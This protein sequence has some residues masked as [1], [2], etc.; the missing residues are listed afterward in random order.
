MNKLILLVF[1]LVYTSAGAAVNL[2]ND[3]TKGLVNDIQQAER[4]LKQTQ[5][6]IAKDNAVLQQQL[7]ELEKSVLALQAKTAV[8]RRATDEQTLSLETLQTRLHDWQQQYS[9]QNNLL[10]R[11][12]QQQGVKTT[13][14]NT[15][16][17]AILALVDTQLAQL[18]QKSAPQWQLQQLALQDGQL[19]QLKTLT[20]GPMHWF[21]DE[22]TNQ[23]GIYQINQGIAQVALNFSTS[24]SQALLALMQQGQGEVLFDPTLERAMTL[25]VAQESMLDHIKK[26]G[27]WVLPILAFGVFALLIALAKALQLWRLP[28]ILPG[29]STRLSHIFSL[30]AA[31][32]SHELQG[33]QQQ[34]GQAVSSMQHELLAISLNSNIG[35]SRDDQLFAALLH[36]KH[37]LEY[38]LGAIAI[39]AA[40]SPLLGLLGTVS[41]MIETFKLMTL[42]GAGDA[43]AVSGGISEA[44]V[45]TELGLVVAIPALLCHALLSR[46]AKT[47]YGELES[48]AVNLSQL[49]TDTSSTW[50][51]AA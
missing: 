42:F 25:Q 31:Q 10:Q 2:N 41:G 40:V 34:A 37:K 24:D 27:I 3:V 16:F 44:L 1:L 45:T 8:A 38:W 39:T 17:A 49:N 35:P 21:A 20:V 4:A 22:S 23:A 43:A 48:C 6:S 5:Q 15:D 14:N 28:Q 18:S 19:K 30:P 36:H 29:L 50:Q 12:M 7:S 26:G 13:T 32:A 33:L 46:R 11:F 47:Y 9:Y 51:E